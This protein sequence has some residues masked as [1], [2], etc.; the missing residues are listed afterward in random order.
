MKADPLQHGLPMSATRSFVDAIAQ[1]HSVA[2]AAQR[3]QRMLRVASR[4]SIVANIR[5]VLALR[6]SPDVQVAI[7]TELGRVRH[8]AGEP[9]SEAHRIDAL[10]AST[11]RTLRHEA[12]THRLLERESRISSVDVRASSRVWRSVEEVNRVRRQREETSARN[13]VVGRVFAHPVSAAAAAAKVGAALRP[14]ESRAVRFGADTAPPPV[15]RAI[16]AAMDVN[17]LTRDVMR[18]IDERIVAHRERS[19]P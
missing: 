19:S 1:R 18:V 3:T 15:S 8:V 14:A 9:V 12:L 5:H 17:L 16:N 4:A 2:R 13:G 7:A 11:M 10:P 6:F